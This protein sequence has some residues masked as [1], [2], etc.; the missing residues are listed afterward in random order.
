MVFELA[1]ARILA[2]SIGSSTYI[3]TSVIGVIIA[4]LSLG[5]WVGGKVADSRGYMIDVARLILLTGLTAAATLVLYAG[6][7]E[8]TVESFEDPRLQGVMASLLLFAPTSFLLGAISPYLAKLNVRSLKSTGRSIASLSAL[9]SVGGIVGTF[10]AGFILFGFTGSRETLALVAVM[11]VVLS[12]LVVPRVAWKLRLFMSIVTLIMVAVSL[13]PRAG[14]VSIDTPSAHYEVLESTGVRYLVTGPNAAQSGVSVQQPDRLLFWYTQQLADVVRQAKNHQDVLVLGGGAFTLP[15]YLAQKYPD[16][17][18]D[19]VEI[20]PQLAD[21]ARKHFNYKD[22]ANVNLV[23]QDARTYVNQTSKQYDV[24]IIDVYGDAQVPFSFMTREFGEQI[25]RIT[26]QDGVVA[27]NLIAGL[28][29]ECKT[30]F[31]ALSA[32]YMAQFAHGSFRIDRPDE[33]K[34]NIIAVYSR[35]PF[36]WPAALPLDEPAVLYTDNYAPAE[37]LQ[38]NCRET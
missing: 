34:S 15:Q 7:I 28:E 2:P 24:V 23:F 31:D 36:E 10:T 20:D 35:T 14:A 29:G 19:A 12:W 37:R 21:V 5:Y 9:N 8:W 16:S 6:I 3:W 18:I 26:K 17:T 33:E 38:Q 11:M 13:M 25:A 1:G 22:P 27:A 30:L 32:P 4:A